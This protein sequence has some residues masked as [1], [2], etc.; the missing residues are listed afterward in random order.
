MTLELQTL[1][2]EEGDQWSGGDEHERRITRAA[3]QALDAHP[4][5]AE[6]LKRIDADPQR[7]LAGLTNLFDKRTGQ[8]DLITAG[9]WGMRVEIVEDGQWNGWDF[10]A[11]DQGMIFLQYPVSASLFNLAVEAP[12]MGLFGRSDQCLGVAWELLRQVEERQ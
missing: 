6:A 11:G 8:R 1:E 7:R 10:K 5:H 4:R 9:L 12:V 3:Q 2:L